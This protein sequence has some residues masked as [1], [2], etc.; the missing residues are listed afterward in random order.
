M[1]KKKKRCCSPDFSRAPKK[2]GTKPKVASETTS[3]LELVC[4]TISDMNR[5]A[6]KLKNKTTQLWLCS[7]AF[8]CNP[9]TRGE[10]GNAR[11]LKSQGLALPLYLPDLLTAPHA[12]GRALGDWLSWGAWW[13]RDLFGC[14]IPPVLV[15]GS[16]KF[17]TSE[18]AL[19]GK[20]NRI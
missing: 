7:F 8:L 6:S 17:S 3:Y 4:S 12:Q 18:E 2:S 19:P 14:L 5:W 10:A 11:L 16:A 13:E 15:I 20:W 9:Y 1:V